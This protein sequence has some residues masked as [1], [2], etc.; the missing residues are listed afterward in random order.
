MF[1][2]NGFIPKCV[3]FQQIYELLHHE[4]SS[5]ENKIAAQVHSYL[6]FSMQTPLQ[7]LETILREDIQKVNSAC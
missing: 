1:F 7:H 2:H 5:K 3:L 4:S 6:M